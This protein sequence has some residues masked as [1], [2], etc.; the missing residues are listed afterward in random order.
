[1]GA[2]DAV[3][4][5]SKSI[6]VSWTRVKGA[7]RQS[8]DP[9]MLLTVLAYVWLRHDGV[10]V[11]QDH[12]TAG[13]GCGD[14]GVL[15]GGNF[16]VHKTNREFHQL[17]LAEFKTLFMQAVQLARVGR[18]VGGSRHWLLPCG[19][20]DKPGSGTPSTRHFHAHST[21]RRFS[22]N[23]SADRIRGDATCH[24]PSRR[25]QCSD[26]TVRRA[27]GSSSDATSRT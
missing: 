3:V 15:G 8:Y 24:S 20:D 13:D 11:A 22:R 12:P 26:G 16:P 4:T 1:M 14:S 5:R 27:M 21:R 18:L 6:G 10:F 19:V 23:V 9:S 2:N 17:H 25:Y 7:R